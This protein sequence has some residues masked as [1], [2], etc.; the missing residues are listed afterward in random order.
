MP[1][2]LFRNA[3]W[4]NGG[5]GFHMMQP[6]TGAGPQS[7]GTAQSSRASLKVVL[8]VT[9]S[10]NGGTQELF[11]N[12]GEAFQA[13]GH[14]VCLAALYPAATD[15]MMQPNGGLGWSHVQSCRRAADLLPALASFVRRNDP[16]VIL[17]ALP[18]A[19]VL[20]PLAARVAGVRSRIIVTHHSPVGTYSPM[21]NRLDSLTGRLSRV[22]SIVSVSGAV[23]ASLAGRSP[24]YRAKT[25]VIHNSL[26]PA[27]EDHLALL[28]EKRRARP[29]G[30][31]LAALGRLA[32]QKNYPVLL[33]AMARIDDAILTIVGSG[34]DE[35]PLAAL[36]RRLG[37]GE[38]VVFA[39]SKSRLEALAILADSDAFV[40]PSLFEGHSLALIEAAK[41]GVP[42]IV[43][44]VPAQVEGITVDGAACGVVVGVHDDA[45]LAV[46]I[47][48]MLG[49]ADHRHAWTERAEALG[50]STT[51]AR[52][53]D[54]Y[55]AFLR[56]AARA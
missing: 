54:A 20:A 51:F 18:A 47:E 31:R 28:A 44:D 42:L 11:A 6:E 13:R 21:L 15:D 23:D 50:R 52:T 14:E 29:E 37:L 17:T 10:A 4:R 38:R 43:S 46:E 9:H 19:G 25:S 35:Q 7:A 39:G 33:R 24:G 41:L 53:V 45:S 48:K 55:E 49:D 40:Q 27:I 2:A 3:V 30:R 26:P 1:V 32:E 12:L 8:L 5:G 34:P 16:D 36:A 56:S 22:R